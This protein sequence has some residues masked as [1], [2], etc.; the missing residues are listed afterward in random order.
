[1]KRKSLLKKAAKID[2][3]ISDKTEIKKMIEHYNQQKKNEKVPLPI[4]DKLILMVRPEDC[5]ERYL[6]QHQ[7]YKDG[8]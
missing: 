5:N 6:K 2:L 4:G 1:M 3:N 7:E 8:K